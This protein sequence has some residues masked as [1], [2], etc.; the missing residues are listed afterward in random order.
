MNQAK[1]LVIEDEFITAMEITEML[2]LSEY[3]P[4]AVKSREDPVEKAASIRPH[5]IIADIELQSQNDGIKI[6]GEIKKFMDVPVIYI[7]SHSDKKTIESAKLTRPN[8]Y[9][10]KPFE[11]NELI[12]NIKIALYKHEKDNEERLNREYEFF[13]PI[14]SFYGELGAL[15]ACSLPYSERNDFLINFSAI[16]EENFKTNFLK[17][18][19]SGKF[20][21]YISSLSSMLTNLGFANKILYNNSRGYLTIVNCPWRNE[22]YNNEIF[23][24]LCQLM[25]KL[26]FSWA[27][28]VGDV[29][30]ESRFTGGVIFCK[31]KFLLLN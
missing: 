23:C 9:L 28:L 18:L 13:D 12:S 3:V 19:D 27:G 2:K 10:L 4:Y 31:F 16:F 20:E 5:L 15:L 24:H 1:I 17:D 21:D 22:K 25:A 30:N 14:Y 26:T 7:T 6:V 11:W 8:A 29:K